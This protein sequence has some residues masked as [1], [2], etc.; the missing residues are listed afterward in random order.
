VF[1]RDVFGVHKTWNKTCM[2][3]RVVARGIITWCSLCF[4]DVNVTNALQTCN[5]CMMHV[6]RFHYACVVGALRN[7]H[8]RRN[9]ITIFIQQN[10]ILA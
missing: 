9:C 5:D 4:H 7:R 2:W 3:N 6:L 1:S 10:V 8:E